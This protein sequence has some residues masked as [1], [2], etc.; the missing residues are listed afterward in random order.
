MLERNANSTVK[1]LS[2][3]VNKVL[4]TLQSDVKNYANFVS[5]FRGDYNTVLQLKVSEL[6]RPVKARYCVCGVCGRTVSEQESVRVFACGHVAHEACCH[7][8][9][10]EICNQQSETVTGVRERMRNEI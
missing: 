3:I 7:S 5:I 6:K 4:G 9:Y 10:C 1:D 8:N 2:G